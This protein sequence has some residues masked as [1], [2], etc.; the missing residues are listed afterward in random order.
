MVF[1]FFF[2]ITLSSVYFYLQQIL[3]KTKTA[4]FPKMC[5]GNDFFAVDQT[6]LGA[7]VIVWLGAREGESIWNAPF[8]KKALVSNWCDWSFINGKP[9]GAVTAKV[10]SLPF[11]VSGRRHGKG[12]V[13]GAE[14]IASRFGG[15]IKMVLSHQAGPP[16][17]LIMKACRGSPGNI[18]CK[19]I[20]AAGKAQVSHNNAPFLFFFTI[21]GIEAKQCTT[22][23]TNRWCAVGGRYSVARW[24][25]ILSVQRRLITSYRYQSDIWYWYRISVEQVW[26][27]GTS[28]EWNFRDIVGH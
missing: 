18:W 28:F 10:E 17:G 27:A 6:A 12:R 5:F 25:L 16:A 8:N 24:S 3:Q 9:K 19:L 13:N 22:F 11:G 26:Q 14:I 21:C 15:A 2:K 23:V 7:L 20:L 4:D 1:F